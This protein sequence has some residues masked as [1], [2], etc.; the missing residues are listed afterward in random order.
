[1]ATKSK[2]GSVDPGA[3]LRSAR[4]AKGWTLAEVKDR[5]GLPVSTLSKLENGKMALSYDKL[6]KL[7]HGLGVDI[8]QLL[9]GGTANEAVM[10]QF[11]SGR[12]TITR[13]GD[14]HIVESS[15][16]HYMC[17]SA[18]L[19][20]RSMHPMVVD[21]KAQTL[22]EFGEF[23]RHAGEEFAYVLEGTLEFH[24]DLY[25]PAQLNKGDSIYFD[26]GM[27]HAYL[28]VPPGPCTIL[29]VCTNIPDSI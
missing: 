29:A 6:M 25:A 28:R 9:V 3:V 4:A 14:E 23:V 10:P 8:A 16:F 12:R 26:S 22:E 24:C 15:G 13:R 17:H 19:L 2:H 5:T 20:S 11:M 18:E 7:G 27:G 21:L 1:M